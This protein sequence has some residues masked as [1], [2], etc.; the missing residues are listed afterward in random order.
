MKLTLKPLTAAVLIASAQLSGIA[1][2]EATKTP[3]APAAQ[4]A[5]VVAKAPIAIKSPTDWIIYDD[6]IF[7][8][9]ADDVSRHL[10]AAHKAFDA[11]DTRKASAEMRAVAGELKEQA[12]RAA[13]VD[14]ARAK[15]EMKLA[16]DTSR[17][18][19]AVAGKISAAADGIENGKIKTK[20]DLGKAIDKAARAD[21]ERRW[22]VADVVTW[23]PVSEEPQRHFGSAV[24]AYAKKDY[25]AAATE[26]RKAAGYVR[27]E[28]VRATG[29][30]R[31]ALDSSVAELDQL[32]ASVEKGA[33]KD[34][35]LMDKAFANANHALALAH[36]TKAA[37]SWARKEY[38]K[39][40]YELKAAAHGLESAAGWAGAEAK[41]GA[42][43]AVADTQALG[44]K[45]ASGATWTRD[46][47][48]KGFESL[49]NAINALGQKIG[50]SK[51][52]A[53]VNVG[54][55]A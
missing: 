18:M 15:S 25:K 3:V 37:E 49:G 17:R 48:A 40:G 23:Y 50:S 30:A 53:P 47:V 26:I 36:R 21:M 2:A 20:A 38:D 41:A 33:V 28:A 19:D 52:A 11:K 44:G 24:E 10:E 7:T 45:L 51:K 55:G 43:G 4:A 22:L 14:K 39:A 9:V 8:P 42:S 34:E 12:A 6:T 54:L 32:A 27:L 13:K 31:Q 46:E 5:P 16:Q 1:F 35:K 29:N